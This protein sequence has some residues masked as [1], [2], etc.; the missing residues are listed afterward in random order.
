MTY[1]CLCYFTI[2]IAEE[3]KEYKKLLF[4]GT[5]KI[6]GSLLL[7][8]PCFGQSKSIYFQYMA[9]FL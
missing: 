8:G 4:L 3:S 6:G 9:L 2:K 1:I 7:I 5:F